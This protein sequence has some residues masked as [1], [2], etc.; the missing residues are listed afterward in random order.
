M[1]VSCSC[2]WKMKKPF[3]FVRSRPSVDS[4]QERG[5]RVRQEASAVHGHDQRD[6]RR[7]HLRPPPRRVHLARQG[8]ERPRLEQVIPGLYVLTCRMPIIPASLSSSLSI[9]LSFPLSLSLSLSLSMSLA[10]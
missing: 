1:L 4:R 6:C 10:L 7:R 8:M 5:G 2:K 3:H 9:S